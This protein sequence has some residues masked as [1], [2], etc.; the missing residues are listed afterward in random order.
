MESEFEDNQYV[1]TLND[2][3][4]PKPRGRFD[5][6]ISS[7]D[8][9]ENGVVEYAARD[10]NLNSGDNCSE[11]DK[12]IFK[13][14]TDGGSTWNDTIFFDCDDIGQNVNVMFMAIDQGVDGDDDDGDG[15]IDG[16]AAVEIDSIPNLQ[17]KDVT[18]PLTGENDNQF[19]G[20]YCARTNAVIGVTPAYTDDEVL[21][22]TFQLNNYSDN[23]RVTRIRYR[24]HHTPP[25]AY[26]GFLGGNTDWEEIIDADPGTELIDFP[27]E[28]LTL[29]E[30]INTLEF[31]LA[32]G[33]E[34]LENNGFDRNT[35]VQTIWVVTILPKPIP[36]ALI[37]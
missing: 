28:F 34:E 2:V 4:L 22:S 33:S 16:N 25:S 32:D 17:V 6:S 24:I 8:L 19:G 15:L 36:G 11:V 3:E 20:I 27:D 26:S 1:I 18:I 35:T 7:M 29:Y 37:E 30:G 23:C 12:L 9:N 13:L 5:G 10:F 31:E 21:L 14:S